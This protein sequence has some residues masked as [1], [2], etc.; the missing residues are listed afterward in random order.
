MAGRPQIWVDDKKEEAF[1]QVINRICDG[2]SLRAILQCA[3]RDLLPS[4]AVFLK[5]ISEDKELEKQYARAMEIRAEIMFDEII[6]ISD[7]SNPDIDITDD[8]KLRVVGEAIQRSRLKIDARK[9]ALSKMN[10][11]KY[12]EK[13]EIDHKSSDGS[14]ATQPT[15]IVFT[16]GSRGDG[17]GSSG[18]KDK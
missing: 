9:W 12:G 10:P 7:E 5:W 15:K 3:N 16:S 2:E 8:G 1:E 14:M 11:K 13:T 4:V 18:S 17:R 6:E